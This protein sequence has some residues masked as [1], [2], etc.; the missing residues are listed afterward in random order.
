MMRLDNPFLTDEALLQEL[1]A[2]LARAR[3]DR[4]LTQKQLAEEAGV[5][6]TTVERAEAGRSTTVP[7]FLRIL[8]VLRL[9][10]GLEA[11]VPAPT[12]S[13]IAITRLESKQRQRGTGTRGAGRAQAPAADGSFRWGDE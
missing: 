10:D 6:K 3:V 7:N 5:S 1:G 8:R 4:D 2:R 9:L 11:L 13:P 12:I